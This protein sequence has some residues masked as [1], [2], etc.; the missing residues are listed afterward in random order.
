M[1]DAK[2]LK[3]GGKIFAKGNYAAYTSPTHL[4]HQQFI[5]GALGGFRPGD[6][7]GQRMRQITDGNSM[8]LA[9]AEVRIRDDEQDP[10]GAWAVPWAGSS[11]LAADIHFH[12]TLPP[13]SGRIRID[14]PYLPITTYPRSA[15]QFPNSSIGFGDQIRP[16]PDKQA[17][18]LDGMPCGRYQAY[19]TW[20][21]SAATRSRHPG[22]IYSVWLA[23]HVQ[24]V[25]DD[26]DIVTCAHHLCVH[27]GG[28]SDSPSSSELKVLMGATAYPVPGR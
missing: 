22:G 15:T 21:A 26:I 14:A 19:G 24:Y 16:V 9:I 1:P 23:G 8:T 12:P 10:R 6:S 11:L 27:E 25:S 2:P 5:S 4:E 3:T 18:L 13:I 20:F 17:S 7:K 28:Q